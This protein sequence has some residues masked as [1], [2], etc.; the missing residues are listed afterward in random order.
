[1]A[2][3]AYALFRFF[4]ARPRGVNVYLYKT[5]TPSEAAHGRVTEDHPI[6]LY[7]ANGVLTTNGW[8]DLE[9]V[10]WGGTGPYTLISDWASVLTAAGYSVA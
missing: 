5:G 7:D 6:S 2:P 10:F 4:R 3:G 8:E 9:Q 1:M